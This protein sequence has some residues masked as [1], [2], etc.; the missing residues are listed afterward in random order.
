MTNENTQAPGRGVIGTDGIFRSFDEHYDTQ[1]EVEQD[2]YGAWLAIQSLTQI[3]QAERDK[4][5][6]E[7]VEA[8]HH[9]LYERFGDTS[10]WDLC[11][12]VTREL[13]RKV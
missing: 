7:G 10:A 3:H 5:F 9:K 8:L 12:G 11:V 13:K 4:A 2:P 1:R 6:N